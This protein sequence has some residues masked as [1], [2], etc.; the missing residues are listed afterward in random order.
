MIKEKDFIV[1][2]Q[3]LADEPLHSSYIMG[4]M[5][6]AVKQGGCNGIRA[7]S[8]EDIEEIKKN[9][10]LPIIGI[11]KKDYVDSEVYITPTIKEV[12]ELV[13]VGVDV[14]AVD[15]TKRIRPKQQTLEEFFYE[16]K[17]KYPNQKL[18][19]DCS[20]YEE[21]INADKLGFDYI[22][23]TMFGY[24][25][26]SVQS[27]FVDLEDFFEKTKEIKN[28]IIAEGQINTPKQAKEILGLSNVW[29]VVVGGAI[30]RPQQIT[31][32]FIDEI[33]N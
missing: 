20:T 11:I 19:A 14:I 27:A 21:M 3:A 22:G 31:K 15:A 30:T 12:E 5:A 10:N 6:L 28:K 8:V 24:T 9:V 26:Y 23:T 2:C 33:R 7:N 18:M 4:K 1:S 25:S 13:S 17:E 29:A 32:K 16:I